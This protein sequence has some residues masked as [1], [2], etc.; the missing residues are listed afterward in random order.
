MTDEKERYIAFVTFVNHQPYV[1]GHY[2]S[3]E[4]ACKAAE[5]EARGARAHP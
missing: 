3:A 2:D 4:V 5:R 1:V